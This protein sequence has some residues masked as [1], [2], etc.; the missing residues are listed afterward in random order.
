MKSWFY[1]PQNARDSVGLLLVRLVMGAAFLLHGW[2]KIQSPMN[3]MGPDA[4][5]PGAFQA[6]AAVSEFGG[7]ALLI[8]GLLTRLA[9]LGLAGTMAT[10]AYMG[11]ISKGDPFVGKPSE[12]SWE[13]AAIYCACAVLLLLAG[14]GRAS[15][16]ALLFGRTPPPPNN[17]I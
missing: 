16:D 12:P 13:L 7:G 2:G 14:A 5:V 4:P 1:S 10:A 17:Q 8:P 3:W 9:A 6:A 11:H 15:L